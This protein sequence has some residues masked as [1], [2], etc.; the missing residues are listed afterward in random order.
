MP[1]KYIKCNNSPLVSTHTCTIDSSNSRQIPCCD[2]HL[3]ILSIKIMVLT[4][5]IEQRTHT[6]N[7]SALCHHVHTTHSMWL[8][9]LEFHDSRIM[10]RTK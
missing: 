2:Q 8:I 7:L 3:K 4:M 6:T 1:T 10:Q 5:S 9:S